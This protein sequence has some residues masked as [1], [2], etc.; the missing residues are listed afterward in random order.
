[1]RVEL[2]S[3]SRHENG[4]TAPFASLHFA[5]RP[6]APISPAN[7]GYV[8]IYAARAQTDSFPRAFLA[9]NADDA[10]LYEAANPRLAVA[11]DAAEYL[12]RVLAD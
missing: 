5:A 2:S 12:L 1:M 3:R 8:S 11:E 10:G 9:R 6:A 4:R 7:A